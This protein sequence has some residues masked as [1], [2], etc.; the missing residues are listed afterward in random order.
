MSPEVRAKIDGIAAKLPGNFKVKCCKT[1]EEV[2]VRKEIFLK[3]LEKTG[4]DI[5]LLMKNYHG[6]K[7]RKEF[8]CDYLGRPKSASGGA[9][10]LTLEDL[11]LAVDPVNETDD[12]NVD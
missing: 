6:R 10:V 5:T 8:N 11:N 9:K 3:R 4:G 7:A 1:G 2:S 12:E